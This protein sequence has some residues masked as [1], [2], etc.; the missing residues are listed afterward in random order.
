MK[1]Y[2]L[3]ITS[4]TDCPT[5]GYYGENCSIPCPKNCQDG[6][7]NIVEGTC[8]RCLTGYKEQRCNERKK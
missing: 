8:L 7:C 6:Q 2:I 3:H 5:P 4:D 1:Y